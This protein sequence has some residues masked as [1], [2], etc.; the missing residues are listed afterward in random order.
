MPQKM[1]CLTQNLVTYAG[2]PA[3]PSEPSVKWQHY[4]LCLCAVDSRLFSHVGRAVV[5]ESAL[6]LARMGGGHAKQIHVKDGLHMQLIFPKLLKPLEQ[7]RNTCY[8]EACFVSSQI[9]LHCSGP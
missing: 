4:P 7:V 3:P 8:L 9:C 6:V 2:V 1:A 5:A